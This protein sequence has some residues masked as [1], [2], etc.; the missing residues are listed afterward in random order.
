MLKV[1]F[2]GQLV[3]PTGTLD[4]QK[5][6]LYAMLH[7]LSVFFPRL[8]ITSWFQKVSVKLTFFWEGQLEPGTAQPQP[9][10]PGNLARLAPEASLEG[11]GNST[12]VS[13]PPAQD[14][15]AWGPEP[16][17]LWPAAAGRGQEGGASGGGSAF[18]TLRIY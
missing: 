12:E 3:S 17:F 2:M 15:P 6:P 13:C 14:S 9:T 10:L 16:G 1:K 7:G 4:A 8:Q 5:A 11:V 18:S